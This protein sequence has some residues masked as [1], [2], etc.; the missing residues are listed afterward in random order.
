LELLPKFNDGLLNSTP[1]TRFAARIVAES[2]QEFVT[3]TIE[4]MAHYRFDPHSAELGFGSGDEKL[5]AW[6][7]DLDAGHRLIFRGKIDRV[8]LCRKGDT[9]HALAVVIDY[10]SGGLKLDEVL[11]A[12]G[13]QL[14]LAAYLSVLRQ[15]PDPQNYFGVERLV[16]VG[17]FY[18]NL[19][20]QSESGKTRT[21]VLESRDDF[22]RKRYQHLGR[23]DAGALQFLDGS[24]AKEG[25]QFK[26]KIKADGTP[27]AASK[28]VL[29]SDEFRRLLDRVESELVR[30]G[31]EIYAGAIAPN[32]FQKGSDTACAK[33][34][35]IG[36]CRFDSWTQSYRVLRSQ[37]NQ[38]KFPLE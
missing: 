31:N 13:L 8:D 17:V 28:D 3:A 7:L 1:Q 15:L 11:M 18:V 37:K 12:N 27:H 26:F 25:S 6:Q 21:A 9:D 10:K 29:A 22:R 30:M 36:I 32:P 24:G 35:Y 38:A 23:F 2:L 19:C 33:C 4:W 20:G 34:D 14:Q 16:P 5:P